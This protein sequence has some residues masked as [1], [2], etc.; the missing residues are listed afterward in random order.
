M[1]PLIIL[2]YRETRLIRGYNCE[3]KIDNNRGLG[4]NMHYVAY[5]FMEIL[6]YWL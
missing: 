2:L 1:K 3:I 6:E 4:L 5:S